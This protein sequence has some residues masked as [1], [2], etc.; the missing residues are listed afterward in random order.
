MEALP[1]HYTVTALGD[2]THSQTKVT[3]AGVCDIATDMPAEFGGP[4]DQWSPE[5]LLMAAVADCFVLTFRAIA[6]ASK[7]DWAQITCSATGTLDNVERKNRFTHVQL[8]VSLSMPGEF[9]EGRV[10]RLLGKAEE[11]CLITNSLTSEIAMRA[12]VQSS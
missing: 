4:G 7:L 5:S 12:T 9:N 2:S 11:S 3:S 6:K 8:D 10:L 1:H